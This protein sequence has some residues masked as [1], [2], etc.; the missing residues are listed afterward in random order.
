MR[1]H[2]RR[3]GFVLLAAVLAVA[4]YRASEPGNTGGSS[5]ERVITTDG[6]EIRRVVVRKGREV[7]RAP[8]SSLEAAAL[9]KGP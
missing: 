1:K 2:I 4:V 9:P 3:I 7:R 6:G 5:R 8:I